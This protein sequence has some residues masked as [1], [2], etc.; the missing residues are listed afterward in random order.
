MKEKLRAFFR[1]ADENGVTNAENAAGRLDDVMRCPGVVVDDAESFIGFGVFFVFL[2][3]AKQQRASENQQ[4]AGDEKRDKPA[5]RAAKKQDYACRN[6]D[7]SERAFLITALPSLL[8]AAAFS[9]DRFKHTTASLASYPMWMRAFA[10]VFPL[11]RI[12]RF[13]S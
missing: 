7:E 10:C 11:T 2:A 5:R 12:D 1:R 6:A 13:R 8:S 4:R 9:I 3:F